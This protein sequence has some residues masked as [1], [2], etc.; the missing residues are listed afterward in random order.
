MRMRICIPGQELLPE[1]K[2]EPD[3]KVEIS[4]NGERGP[5]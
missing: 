5:G 2:L 1:P 3:G 4:D